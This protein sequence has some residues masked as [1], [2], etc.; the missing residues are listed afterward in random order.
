[1]S[2][3]VVD[4]I[5]IILYK[6]YHVPMD[7]HYTI[8]T[9]EARQNLAEIIDRVEE[10]GARYTLTVNGKPKAV[11]VNADELEA[12]QETVDILTDPVLMKRIRLGKRELAGADVVSLDD[13]LAA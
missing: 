8:S 10:S 3:K 12:L 6:I 2:E 1:L 11:L 4:K 13:L 7:A 9:T 5:D